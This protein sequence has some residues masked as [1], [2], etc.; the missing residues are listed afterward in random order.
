MATEDSELASAARKYWSAEGYTPGGVIQIVDCDT[1]LTEAPDL[2]TS[3]ASA[4]LKDRVPV[5]RRV[6]GVDR[7][8]VGD[9]D[10]GSTGGNVIDTANNKL[11]GRLAFPTLEEG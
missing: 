11:L 7:W 8:F 2:F 9:R 4:R 5:I 6:N 10:F 3:R 1:H